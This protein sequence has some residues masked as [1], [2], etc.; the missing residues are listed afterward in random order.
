[1]SVTPNNPEKIVT[2]TCG[3][4]ISDTDT[5]NDGVADCIDN[6]PAVVNTDQFDSN[7][8]G[9]GDACESS[10]VLTLVLPIGGEVIPSGGGPMVYVGK[11][12]LTQ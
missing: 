4:G 11:H 3:C 7:R 8:N 1:M 12:L 6:C 5:D 10:S 9:I 2:G